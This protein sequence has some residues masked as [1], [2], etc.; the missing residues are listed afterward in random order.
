LAHQSWAWIS[1]QII[2]WFRW[3]FVRWNTFFSRI[4]DK[5]KFAEASTETHISVQAFG[6]FFKLAQAIT[7]NEENPQDRNC[8]F[9]GHIFSQQ[10]PFSDHIRSNPLSQNDR[11][12]FKDIKMRLFEKLLYLRLKIEN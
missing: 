8:S 5:T 1:V 2:T 11:G 7:H 12:T 6:G 10:Q 4:P 9:S 3:A